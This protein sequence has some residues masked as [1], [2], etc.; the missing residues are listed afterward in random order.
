MIVRCGR[1]IIEACLK[2]YRIR[3]SKNHKESPEEKECEDE[4]D[5]CLDLLW[6]ANL[7]TVKIR[8]PPG[9]DHSVDYYCHYNQWQAESSY[10]EVT[11]NEALYLALP[12]LVDLLLNE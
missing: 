4:V 8:L 11:E 7:F 12:Q 1:P 6:V 9:Y 10:Y 2:T 3:E 5:S